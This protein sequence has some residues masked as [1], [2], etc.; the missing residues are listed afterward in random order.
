MSTL[1]SQPAAPNRT[2]GA[3]QANSRDVQRSALHDLVALATESAATEA[4]I[5][6][7]F[8]ASTEGASKEAE[9]SRWTINARYRGYEDSL[10]QK[11]EERVANA[12]SKYEADKSAL[13]QSLRETRER[14]ERE[15]EP[16]DQKMKEKLQQAVWL[17]DS[18]LEVAQNQIREEVKKS[19]DA[20]K[21]HNEALDLMEGRAWQLLQR[22]RQQLPPEEADES[23]APAIENPEA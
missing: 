5:E 2:A 9:K 15:H 17:A 18:V 8:K 10:R 11:H 1:T 16:L 20:V 3:P 23:P 4:E 13:E 21:A 19:H 6:G 7:L 22:Y 12:K 14:I